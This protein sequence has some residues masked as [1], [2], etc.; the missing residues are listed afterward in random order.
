MASN[1]RY[2]LLLVCEDPTR[3]IAPLGGEALLRAI[4]VKRLISPYAEAVADQWAEVY[5]KAGPAAH[6][7]FVRGAWSD[8]RPLFEEAVIRFGTT[9]VPIPFGLEDTEVN[10]FIELRGCLFEDV[11]GSFKTLFKDILRTRAFTSL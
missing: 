8:D 5:C 10:F 1:P 2:D 7:A 4:A 9:P 11:L 3:R 6:E